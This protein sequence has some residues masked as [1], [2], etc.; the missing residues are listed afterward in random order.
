MLTR[1]LRRRAPALVLVERLLDAGAAVRVHDP[2]ALETI[3]ARFGA[4][5]ACCDRMYDATFVKESVDSTWNC[6]GSEYCS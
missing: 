1:F 3:R 5:V 4:R 6:R 2:V